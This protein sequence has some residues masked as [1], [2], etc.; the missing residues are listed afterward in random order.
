MFKYNVIGTCLEIYNETLYDVLSDPRSQTILEIWDD[1]EYG[2]V[3]PNLV[4][5]NIK[6]MSVVTA[7][8]GVSRYAAALQREEKNI[9]D[10]GK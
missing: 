9:Q 6:N 1:T 5:I 8:H 7:V 10:E 4:K 3:I 2:P